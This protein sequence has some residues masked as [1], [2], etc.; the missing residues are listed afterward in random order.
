MIMSRIEL[1]VVSVCFLVL[2]IER[3][4][5]LVGLPAPV[6]ALFVD[7]ARGIA[8]MGHHALPGLS[9]DAE[10]VELVSEG[11]SGRWKEVGVI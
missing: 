10:V 7:Q 8:F 4:C 1:E 3:S 6:R 5:G 2:P 9:L 11:W